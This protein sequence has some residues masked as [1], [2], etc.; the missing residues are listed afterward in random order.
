MI[1]G[2]I[3][4]MTAHQNWMGANAHNVANSNT[5]NFEASRTVIS[6]GPEAFQTPSGGPTDLSKALPEL[7][8]I[9][10]GFSAQVAAL[11]SQD[12]MLGTLLDMKG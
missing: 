8:V 6:G 5:E 7:I 9:A 2:N 12:A 3:S 10:G 11:K 1:S 4:G